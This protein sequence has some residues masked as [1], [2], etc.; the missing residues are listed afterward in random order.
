MLVTL[1]EGGAF[2]LT[3]LKLLSSMGD[4]A[5][6]VGRTASMTMTEDSTDSMALEHALDSS[7]ATQNGIDQIASLFSASAATITDSTSTE[8]EKIA[9]FAQVAQISATA[10]YSTDPRTMQ[11]AGRIAALEK[12]F[13]A[14]TGNTAFIRTA[15]AM[16]DATSLPAGATSL[17][18]GLYTAIQSLRNP[19][20]FATTSYSTTERID[21]ISTSQT[22]AGITSSTGALSA[23]VTTT[24]I[25]VQ[26]TYGI[27]RQE[28]LNAQIL[29]DYIDPA[30]AG[31][32]RTTTSSGSES[33]YRDFRS[34]SS[35]VAGAGP[36][37]HVAAL[38]TTGTDRTTAAASVTGTTIPL[39][40][41]TSATQA[42]PARTT[43]NQ[44]IADMLFG[45]TPGG[46]QS[47]TQADTVSA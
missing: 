45:V 36:S 2:A 38:A 33:I 16:A 28:I 5:Q 17:E 46:R 11:N 44:Q 39:G 13:Y 19:D 29:P 20:N 30:S 10:R 18:T 15:V 8:A 47:K 7:D 32:A 31:Q 24:D 26:F 43:L 12:A 21:S 34:T 22:R 9:A 40:V 3:S 42:G 35:A 23:S 4:G 37:L 41:F 25:S 6:D 14:A 27:S 1:S